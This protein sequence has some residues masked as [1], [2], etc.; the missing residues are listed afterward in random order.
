MQGDADHAA[1][2]E[3]GDLGGGRDGAGWRVG[4]GD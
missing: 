1:A 2:G 4:G 3:R